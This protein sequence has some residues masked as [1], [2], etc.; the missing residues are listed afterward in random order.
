MG[1]VGNITGGAGVFLLLF[2][3]I[4]SVAYGI[5]CIINNP[6]ESYSVNNPGRSGVFYQ[7]NLGIVALGLATLVALVLYFVLAMLGKGLLPMITGIVVSVLWLGVLITEVIFML[8]S[9]NG[10]TTA[11]KKA[12]A[13]DPTIIKFIKEG[14][15]DSGNIESYKP[16]VD[17][18]F[19][20]EYLKDIGKFWSV[21]QKIE[22]FDPK[23][24]YD[25]YECIEDI[26]APCLLFKTED[27]VECVGSWTGQ[28]FADYL[29]SLY[30]SFED[31]S[32][33]FEKIEDKPEKVRADLE[34]SVRLDEM[35]FS[36]GAYPELGDS[37]YVY[38]FMIKMFL[39]GQVAGIICLII[40]IIVNK[41]SSGGK[42]SSSNDLYH[43]QHL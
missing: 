28:K 27:K 25:E 16:E 37:P 1:S 2:S 8:W 9:F 38:Y 6:T 21:C 3:L 10:S 35:Y 40:S 20:F 4:A 34:K 42:E 30:K 14:G 19:V 13:E 18:D 26:N 17:D 11:T 36:L 15:F 12:I 23:S 32:K 41:V 29:N 31:Q 33:K 24:N 5:M 39:G 43:D 22:N 7:L